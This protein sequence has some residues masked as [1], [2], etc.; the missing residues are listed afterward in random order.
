VPSANPANLGRPALSIKVDNAPSARPQSGLNQADLVTEEL[1]EGGL[2]RFLATY[3]SQDAPAVGPIRSARLVD[4]NLLRELGGGIFAYSGAAAGELAPIRATSGALLLTPDDGDAGFHRDLSRLAPSNVYA[5][6]AGLYQGGLARTPALAPPSP[7]FT[8]DSRAPAGG[9]AT[10]ATLTF[11]GSA[12][13]AWTWSADTG[14]YARTENGTPHLLADGQQV[15]AT[16]VVI[17]SV[18]LRSTG[19]VDAAHN[20]VPEVIVTGSGPCWV[21]RDG[22]V[23]QGSWQRPS[24]AGALS[25]VGSDGQPLAL[26]PGRIWLEL[27]PLP[28]IPVVH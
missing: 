22:V 12:N 24:A 1:V 25:L 18:G 21:L 9:S 20:P 27:L 15:S 8:F 26:R 3:Q 5:S 28:G 2:T 4:A 6:T 13:A 16:D 11:S 23:E 17:L 10:V 19:F 7:L 14:S